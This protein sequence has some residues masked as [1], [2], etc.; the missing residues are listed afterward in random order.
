ME[1]KG[2][3]YSLGVISWKRR[4]KISLGNFMEERDKTLGVI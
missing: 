4:L 1:E 3:T 2:T